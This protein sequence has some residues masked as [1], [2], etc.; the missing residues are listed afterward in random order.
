MK[1]II[2]ISILSVLSLTGCFL[3]SKDVDEARMREEAMY[4]IE[5]E[6]NEE[7]FCPDENGI[8][9]IVTLGIGR[10]NN[11]IKNSKIKDE[12]LKSIEGNELNVIGIKDSVIN[13]RKTYMKNFGE[14]E[15]PKEWNNGV[16]GKKVVINKDSN[17]DI[18]YIKRINS[19]ESYVFYNKIENTVENLEYIIDY[20]K[21][22]N[23]LKILSSEIKLFC[24]VGDYMERILYGTQKSEMWC[25][26]NALIEIEI[27]FDNNKYTETLLGLKFYMKDEVLKEKYFDYGK[28]QVVSEF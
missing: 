8:V 25:F 5:Y 7:K 6:A 17:K 16:G 9:E 26:R 21:E 18:K 23:K 14:I 10:V 4:H 20:K 13:Y 1:K 22:G 27:D 3:I 2:I 28:Y 24:D 12:E 15:I 11:I 19:E